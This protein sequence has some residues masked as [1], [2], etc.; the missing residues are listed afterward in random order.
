MSTNRTQSVRVGCA[1]MLLVGLVGG[2]F[3]F[4]R[5]REITSC[6]TDN[7]DRQPLLRL[8]VT[9]D[10]SQV[11]QFVEQTRQFAFKY[12]FRFD[13]DSDEQ[14]GDTH[15][16]MI[17]KEVEIIAKSPSRPGGYEVGFYNY[18]CIHPIAA[19][20]IA[21]L[22]NDFKGFMIQIPNVVIAE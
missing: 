19:A 4:T 12:N 20:D 18:D 17:G 15:V 8:S 16:R 13:T 22:V 11:G 6:H 1:V 9:V 7:A 2:F 14:G 5:Y 21:D 10:P 3:L